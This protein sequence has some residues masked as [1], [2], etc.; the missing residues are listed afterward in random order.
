LS[1]RL[2]PEADLRKYRG[3]VALLMR[4]STIATTFGIVMIVGSLPCTFVGFFLLH[5]PAALEVGRAAGR[6]V[7]FDAIGV[8]MMAYFAFFIALGSCVAGLLYFGFAALKRKV[9]LKA[10]H[11]FGI[12]YSLSQVTIAVIYVST[13][14]VTV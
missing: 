5:L 6:D 14:P 2:G 1:D 10:W 3:K 11:V 9:A 12:V 13:R 4:S 8:L 7:G